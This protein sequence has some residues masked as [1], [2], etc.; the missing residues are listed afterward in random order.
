MRST[1]DRIRHAISFEVIG[2]LAVTP[3]GS[4]VFGMEI[5]A[6]GVVVLAGASL[7]T[8]WTYIYNLGFDHAMLRWLGHCHKSPLMRVL[9]ALLLEAGLL[10]VLLPFT[11]WYLQIGLWTALIMDLGF[12]GFYLVYAF[13]FNWAYDVIFPIPRQ[14]IRD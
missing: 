14:P 7:A 4:W 9:H 13:C 2:L 1:A 12:S 11:A 3:L 8:V 5:H 6:I 10:A